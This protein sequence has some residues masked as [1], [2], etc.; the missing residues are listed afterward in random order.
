MMWI[1]NLALH[2]VLSDSLM[3]A[4]RSPG[5]QAWAM[6]NE[7]PFAGSTLMCEHF[8]QHAFERQSHGTYSIGLTHTLLLQPI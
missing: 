5:T 6:F 1:V 7:V 3:S 2:L 8:C 4:Q